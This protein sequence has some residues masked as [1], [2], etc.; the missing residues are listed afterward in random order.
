M[1]MLPLLPRAF[2]WLPPPRLCG[3]RRATCD[4]LPLIR[5]GRFVELLGYG[6][7]LP[8]APSN[9]GVDFLEVCSRL[10]G[11]VAL[12]ANYHPFLRVPFP[13]F[14]HRACAALRARSVRWAG[15]IVSRDRLPRPYH[16]G[17]Q[18]PASLPL[19]GN[20]AVYITT[21]V[22]IAGVAGDTGLLEEA[23]ESWDYVVSDKVVYG[24]ESCVPDLECTSCDTNW[25]AEY[26]LA[27]K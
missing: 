27:R 16:H 3:L 6:R 21:K 17:F 5:R 18:A 8:K 19:T 15:V 23:L 10:L 13:G 26:D 20:I 4:R 2:P 14:A 25:L 11:G 22:E 24:A 9:T 12:E 7:S 1:W